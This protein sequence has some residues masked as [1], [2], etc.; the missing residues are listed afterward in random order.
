MDLGG[1]DPLYVRV[2]R[3]RIEGWHRVDASTVA[4][5][6]YGATATVE[7]ADMLQCCA[8]LCCVVGVMKSLME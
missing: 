2:S 6:V 3:T 7:T 8:R 5:C 1:M 4:V